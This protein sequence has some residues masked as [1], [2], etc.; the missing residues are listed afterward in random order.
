[1]AP[2][3]ECLSPT[4]QHVVAIRLGSLNTEPSNCFSFVL[5]LFTSIQTRVPKD[6][7]FKPSA[8]LVD[9]HNATTRGAKIKDFTYN[10][11]C[12]LQT[13]RWRWMNGYNAG[14][15][16]VLLLTGRVNHHQSLSLN[17]H[18]DS[19]FILV[20]DFFSFYRLLYQWC[21]FRC[22]RKLQWLNKELF[23]IKLK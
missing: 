1:M 15:E 8:E 6:K 3:P 12:C 11:W 14:F 17:V 5:S 2:R 10:R 7:G 18:F 20:W 4:V 19:D 16:D 9:G 21:R 23:Y 22:R 13:W